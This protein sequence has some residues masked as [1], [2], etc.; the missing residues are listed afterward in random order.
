MLPTLLILSLISTVASL[1]VE[2]AA[3][4]AAEKPTDLKLHIVP[5]FSLAEQV[6]EP[7]DCH[8]ADPFKQDCKSDEMAAMIAA[9]PT[10]LKI[11]VSKCSSDADC[12]TDTCPGVVSIPRCFLQ[13]SSGQKFCGLP[14]MMG[15]STKC[16]S[17]EHM[18]CQKEAGGG[19]CAYAS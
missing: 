12:P 5:G 16:S 9:Q 19:I 6:E 14:C 10:N 1:T 3:E 4:K 8:Y 2:A 11:C 18:V 13:D 7:Q 17:D 15:K